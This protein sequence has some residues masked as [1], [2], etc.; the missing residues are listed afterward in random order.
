MLRRLALTL[1]LCAP[2]VLTAATEFS[3]GL[4][5][6]QLV[7]E[8][9]AGNIYRSLPDNFPVVSLPSGTDVRILGS[10]QRGL[11]GDVILTA[12]NASTLRGALVAAYVGAGW[13][14]LAGSV[15]NYSR[16][17]HDTLGTLTLYSLTPA[18]TSL[19]VMYAPRYAGATPCAQQVETTQIAWTT[20]F[21]NLLPTLTP[22]PQTLPSTTPIMGYFGG[23]SSRSSSSGTT[24]STS[25]E[26]SFRVPGI[27]MAGLYAHFAA[28]LS[29]QGWVNDSE[30]SGLK[31]AA[32]VW[33]RTTPP[34]QGADAD[35]TQ[36][37][38]TLVI[39]NQGGDEYLVT[40]SLQATTDARVYA[41][42]TSIARDFLPY[43][44][45]GNGVGPPINSP[46]LGIRG[47]P[48]GFGTQFGP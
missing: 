6:I 22:P 30:D 13:V 19:R 2:T 47:I 46:Q 26:A 20:Y 9:M 33:L 38:G 16:L 31:S 7:R 35:D 23:I 17:C 44:I 10:L 43:D 25:R 45:T 40:F 42:G 14:D 8:F 34:P 21:L 1:G 28:R 39:L 3:D 12:Q 4:V 37:T 29:E 41:S 15:A 32:S 27:N 24:F 36:L 5:P 11:N 48:A 18:A